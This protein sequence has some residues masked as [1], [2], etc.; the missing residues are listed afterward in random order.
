MVGLVDGPN[1]GEKV[2]GCVVNL[3]N[4]EAWTAIRKQGAE[5]GG[6]P[7]KVMKRQARD[8]LEL[9]ALESLPGALVGARGLIQRST[10]IRILGS[11]ALAIAHTAAGSFRPFCA[12]VPVRGF[13]MAASLLNLS[14]AGGGG[15]DV[16]GHALS[17]LPATLASRTSPGF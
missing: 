12:P 9:I 5:R 2:G 13:D 17:A 4:G 1:I 7:I 15:S 8:R 3:I 11:L 14:A 10:K 16:K 6:E